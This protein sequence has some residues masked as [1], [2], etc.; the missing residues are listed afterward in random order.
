MKLFKKF[1][2]FKKKVALCSEMTGSISYEDL[3]KITKKLKKTIPEKSFIF[4]ISGNNIPS[5]LSYIFSIQSNSIIMLID[6]NTQKKDILNLLKKY[7]PEY[8][9]APTAI[10]RIHKDFKY[11]KDFYNYSIL[12][13]LIEKIKI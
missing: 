2:N 12:K 4:L 10:S 13:H 1:R 3:I 9:I 11:L 7:K 6:I 5:I 8:L